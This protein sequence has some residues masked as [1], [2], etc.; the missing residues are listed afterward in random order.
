MFLGVY[1]LLP[2]EPHIQYYYRLVIA[3]HIELEETALCFIRYIRFILDLLGIFLNQFI[4]VAV[5]L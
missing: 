3:S 2:S 5:F 1:I 4:K